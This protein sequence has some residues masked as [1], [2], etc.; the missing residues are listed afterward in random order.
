[1]EAE[2]AERGR[3]GRDRLR[4]KIPL[5]LQVLLGFAVGV[6]A[7]LIVNISSSADAEAVIWFISHVTQ[8]LSQLF[9]RFLFMLVLPLIFATLTIG[10]AEMGDVRALGRT[11]WR[12]AI[13]TVAGCLVAVALGLV[14]V[15]CL[16]PGVGVD[17]TLAQKLLSGASEGARAILSGGSANAGMQSWVEI[18]PSNVFRA[19]AQNE[20]LPIMIFATFLG[21]GFVLTPGPA[22]HAFKRTLEGLYGVCVTLIGLVIRCAPLAIACLIFNLTTLFGWS[23]FLRLGA[24]LGVVLLA[25]SIQ[26][27]VVYPLC[28][29]LLG[30]MSPVF[31]ARQAYEA[32]LV[33]FSTASSTATLPTTLIVAEERLRLPKRIARFVVT[34]G[35]ATNHHGTA[36]F[37][38]VT[39]LFLAQLFRIEL[40]L[41]QQFMVMLVCVL[42]SIG[43]ATVPAGSLPV[44]AGVLSLFGIP[45]EG[46]GLILGVDRLLD[47]Y[48]SMVNVAGDLTCAVV[49]SRWENLGRDEAR[50]PGE[51][52]P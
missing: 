10:V 36:L 4:I 38:G 46:I 30:A 49:V 7:G 32:L 50:Q 48:R 40:D 9:L 3:Q 28:L 44:I 13:F 42:S 2:R 22:A 11:G 35:A 26:L 47:M 37:E 25:L 1:V 21:V 14:L 33:A 51:S 27:I 24:Y 43:M 29:R 6:C 16:R 19:A 15:N 17:P 8:P 5:H 31:F 41:S 20:L 12:T 39:V 23:L 18:V 45:P 52:S 34:I